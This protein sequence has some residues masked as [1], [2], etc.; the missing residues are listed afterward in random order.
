MSSNVEAAVPSKLNHAEIEQCIA[1]IKEGE[2][3]D[4]NS[5]RKEI[6][7]GMVAALVREGP[8]IVGCGF[9]K[10]KRSWYANGVI[11]HSGFEFDPNLHELGY[12]AVTSTHRG[13]RLSAALVGLLLA[14]FSERPLFATTS[15]LE[16]KKTLER[17]GFVQRGK[18]WPNKA[19]DKMLSLWLLD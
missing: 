14:T 7:L 9:I 19:G 2:A 17:A 10:R 5:A 4:V 3:V 18:E 6:P 15:R 11:E 13:R 1:V 16:M 8:Q 12:V